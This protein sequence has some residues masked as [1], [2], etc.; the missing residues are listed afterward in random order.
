M[1]VYRYVTFLRTYNVVIRMSPTSF[2]RRNYNVVVYATL[3]AVTFLIGV[4]RIPS[5]RAPHDR[6]P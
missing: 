3:A 2:Y 4:R 6:P 1:C 5:L